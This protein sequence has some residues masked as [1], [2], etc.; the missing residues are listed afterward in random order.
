MESSRITISRIKAESNIVTKPLALDAVNNRK[1]TFVG[2]L[3][4]F[5]VEFLPQS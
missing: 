2:M 4:H 3:I 1:D 5:E